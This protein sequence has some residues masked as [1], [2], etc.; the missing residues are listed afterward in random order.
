MRRDPP[1]LPPLAESAASAAVSSFYLALTLNKILGA[2]TP[3]PRSTVEAG[4][5]AM[6]DPDYLRPRTL[7]DP[8]DRAQARKEWTDSLRS[9]SLPLPMLDAIPPL[10][11]TDCAVEIDAS[12]QAAVTERFRAHRR[13][14]SSA[15]PAP[16]SP[17]SRP[18]SAIPSPVAEVEVVPGQ[19][20]WFRAWSRSDADGKPTIVKDGSHPSRD[21]K[22]PRTCEASAQPIP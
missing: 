11:A 5:V 9:P 16:P 1:H 19:D 10:L 3:T 4:C 15:K 14:P 6:A 21:G 17:A 13:R 22:R 8:A 7:T 12:T 20:P 18:R 2:P